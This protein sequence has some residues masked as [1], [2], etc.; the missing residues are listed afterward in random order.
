MYLWFC[1]CLPW[2]VLSLSFPTLAIKKGKNMPMR[3][4]CSNSDLFLTYPPLCK[5]K[6]ASIFHELRVSLFLFLQSCLSFCTLPADRL[7]LARTTDQTSF[8]FLR[9]S[10]TDKLTG[11]KSN[12]MLEQTLLS[13]LVSADNIS[14]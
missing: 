13:L 5:T 12:P 4:K 2:R 11:W 14:G 3:L 1:F 9:L 7:Q 6:Y 10:L 8:Q